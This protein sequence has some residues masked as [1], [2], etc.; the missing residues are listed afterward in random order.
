[1]MPASERGVILINVLLFVAV[2]AGLVMLMISAEDVGAERALKMREA[3]RALAVAYGGELSAL[4]ALRRDAVESPAADYPAEAWGAVAERGATIEDG[5]FALAIADA[6]GRFNLNSLMSGEVEPVLILDRIVAALGLDPE[7]AILVVQ[8]VRLYGPV[9]DLTPLRSAGLDAETVE[10]LLTLVTV[11]PGTTPVNANAAS[12]TL[13]AIILDNPQAARALVERREQAGFLVEEDIVG[14][15]VPE[16]VLSVTSSHFWVRTRVTI[17]DTRQQLTS[18]ISRRVG[19]DGRLRVAV[20]ARWR[21]D[22]GP[23][24]APSLGS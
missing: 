12:E 13:L 7:L 9:A 24:E 15:G 18:L 8:H 10:R 17:G 1:M 21:G 4:S 2:A 20:A 6:Q 5:R 3:D 23:P 14:Q 11:L 16:E 19:E 22:A